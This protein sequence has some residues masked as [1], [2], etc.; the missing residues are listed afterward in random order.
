[1]APAPRFSPEEHEQRIVEAAI[2]VI[3]ESSLMGFK[4]SDIAKHAGISMGSVY[5]HVQTKED[6][7]LALATAHFLRLNQNF[8]AID[9]LDLTTPERYMAFNLMDKNK[10][11]LFPFAS[12]LE[13]LITN[14][15]VLDCGS[16]LWKQKLYAADNHVEQTCRSRIDK[17][18]Q[19]GEL[20]A[21]K[22]DPDYANKFSLGLWAISVGLIHVS[23][24]LRGKQ[25]FGHLTPSDE[26]L[27]HNSLQVQVIKNYINSF[28]W[29]SPLTDHGIQRAINALTQINL[30]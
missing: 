24:Q 25:L 26:L 10:A 15:A 5:K 27:D 7:L 29:Q 9:Q 4:M 11:C 8:N 28:D 17:A 21:P 2:A 6:V 13:M 23:K 20:L 22:D 12:H 1:M 16:E 19:S 30:R 3:S 14:D 18:L